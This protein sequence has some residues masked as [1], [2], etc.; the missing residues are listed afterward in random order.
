[1]VVIETFLSNDN[2]DN[3]PVWHPLSEREG[4]PPVAVYLHCPI[5]FQVAFELMQVI[6]GK[7][8]S[9][10]PFGFV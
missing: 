9:I 6:T 1:M 5:P 3:R 4:E 10:W 2:P 8:H 7:A